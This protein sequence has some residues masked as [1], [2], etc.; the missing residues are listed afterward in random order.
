MSRSNR[1]SWK[2]IV[3][4]PFTLPDA[5]PNEVGI[6]DLAEASFK[7]S[8]TWSFNLHRSPNFISLVSCVRVQLFTKHLILKY[9]FICHKVNLLCL[10]PLCEAL[11]H[12]FDLSLLE[13]SGT[14]KAQYISI[15][16]YEFVQIDSACTST[17]LSNSM[18]HL[19]LFRAQVVNIARKFVIIPSGGLYHNL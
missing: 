19:F 1:T 12:C 7:F 18:H 4:I 16:K 14:T 2:G 8:R 10:S 9:P 15:V 13:F 6:T 17:P 11:N 3:P 5:V